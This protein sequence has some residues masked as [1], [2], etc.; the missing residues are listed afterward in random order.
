MFASGQSCGPRCR[1]SLADPGLTALL[2]DLQTLLEKATYRP[3][4]KPPTGFTIDTSGSTEATDHSSAES[5]PAH[6]RPKIGQAVDIK[7]TSAGA[8]EGYGQSSVTAIE[9]ASRMLLEDPVGSG[10][11]I[12]L[13]KFLVRHF[14]NFLVEDP[15]TKS[16]PTAAAIRFAVA[17]HQLEALRRHG[18]LQVAS[19]LSASA[20]SASSAACGSLAA[21]ASFSA[22][23]SASAS[24]SS[25]SS[26]LD[27]S[28]SSDL[29]ASSPS[30]SCAGGT[31]FS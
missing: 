29:S 16:P 26:A 24:R 7:A 8:G 2:G 13:G 18:E 3:C 21:S 15:R 20:E 4:V 5:S 31:S 9:E 10:T 14:K 11:V 22:S 27:G 25:A 23:S 17:G 12:N 1:Y 28:A 19:A 6:K 30:S